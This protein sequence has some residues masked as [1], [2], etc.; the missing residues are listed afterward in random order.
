MAELLPYLAVV[1]ALLGL[2]WASVVVHEAGHYLLGRCVGVPASDMKIHLG[3]PSYVALRHGQRWVCPDDE[4]YIPAFVRHAPSRPAAW[5]FVTG[6][7]LIETCVVQLLVLVLAVQDLRGVALLVLG[8]S[9]VI[10]VLYLLLDAV[11]S[12]RSG[13]TAGDGSAMWRISAPA[14]LIALATFAG[15]RVMTLVLL[16]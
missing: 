4:G 13:A 15:V 2:L 6:G 1:P 3:R 16:L 9:S 5:S 10:F 14:T 7:F 12:V 11:A 8:A